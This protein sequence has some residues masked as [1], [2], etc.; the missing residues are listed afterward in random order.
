MKLPKR[1]IKNLYRASELYAKAQALVNEV[2]EYISNRGYGL[3]DYRNG[4]GISLEEIEYSAGDPLVVI[5]FEVYAKN[6]FDFEKTR[7]EL[8]EM[9]I[10]EGD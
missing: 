1:L 9:G 3:T 10:W 6:D 7:T 8:M 5:R 4:D 2:D